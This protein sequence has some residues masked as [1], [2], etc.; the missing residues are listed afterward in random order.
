M[1]VGE[2]IGDK[3]PKT[4]SRLEPGG[5]ISRL[6]VGALAGGLLGRRHGAS[7]RIGA[8]TGMAAAFTG[9]HAGARWRAIAAGKLGGHDVPGALAEDVVVATLAFAAVR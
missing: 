6:V 4:P 5:V 1:S 8:T 3:L 7:I 9:T 2:V